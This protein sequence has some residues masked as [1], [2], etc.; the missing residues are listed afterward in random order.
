M[1]AL[2]GARVELAEVDPSL[3]L[4]TYLRTRTA[5]RGTKRGCGEG[6]LR[7]RIPFSSLRKRAG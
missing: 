6:E 5:L 1:F 4:L 3:T 7:D 2:N